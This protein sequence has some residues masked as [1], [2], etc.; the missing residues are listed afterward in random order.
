MEFALYLNGVFEGVLEEIRKAQSSKT[1]LVCYLQPY[2]SDTIVK[3]AEEPPTPELKTTLYISTTSSLP[4]VSYRAEIV[5]WENKSE[6]VFKRL[7]TL[8]THIKQYQP[9]ETEIYM[10]GGND[11]P[12]VNLISIIHLER[13]AIP[14]PVTS[15]VKISNN[16]P[17]KARRTSGGWSYVK[18]V[19]DW[20]GTLSETTIQDVLNNEINEAVK[21]SLSSTQIEREK[22]LAQA[23]LIPEAIQTISK[24]FKRNPDV[25]ASVLV[26]ANG[27]CENCGNKAP[28]KRAKDGTPYLE[29]HHNVLLSQGGEDSVKN[30]I[31]V[32]P[33]C[34]RMLHFGAT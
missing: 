18:H 17:L 9:N 13:L 28:F 30:A 33:N 19:P 10:T 29:V 1:D 2:S 16:T 7:K 22:R 11:K 32:C 4:F 3:L 27:L 25:I 21:K 12:S 24:G 14:I 20:V 5:G 34:H 23:P 15:F 26:R 6:I 31:A 8:N